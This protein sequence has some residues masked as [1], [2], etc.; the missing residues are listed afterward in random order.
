MAVSPNKTNC[1]GQSSSW[2][3]FRLAVSTSNQVSVWELSGFPVASS[4]NRENQFRNI[5]DSKVKGIVCLDFSPDGTR[6]AAANRLSDNLTVY[7]VES[8]ASL[9]TANGPRALGCVQFSPCGERIALSGDDAIVNLFDAKSGYRLLRLSGPD[10]SPGTISINSQVVFSPDG[11]RI[12][13]NTWEGKIRYWEV[14]NE[15]EPDGTDPE[16][17][18]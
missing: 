16:P 6:L 1:T 9:Y 8:G 10:P 5:F 18:P 3:W 2:V 12:A 13:T 4:Q 7:D 15:D 14:A 11:R 17:R